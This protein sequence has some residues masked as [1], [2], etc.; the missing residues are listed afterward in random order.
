MS[1]EYNDAPE[2]FEKAVWEAWADLF[3]T[4]EEAEAAIKKFNDG[5]NRR[6]PG[7]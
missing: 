3:I 7:N 4:T 5:W 2:T 1:E 6:E